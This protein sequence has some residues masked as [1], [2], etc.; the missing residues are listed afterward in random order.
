MKPEW[1][2]LNLIKK[3]LLFTIWDDPGIPFSQLY[4]DKHGIHDF[5]NQDVL[6]S[7]VEVE[8]TI[9]QHGF[10]MMFDCNLPAFVEN[11]GKLMPYFSDTMV[12]MKRLDN[13]QQCMETVLQK[14]VPGDFIETGVW[15]GG[16]CIL[17]RAV[18]AAYGYKDRTVYAADSFKGLPVPNTD[19]YPQDAGQFLHE[20]D[21]LAVKREYVEKRFKVF[22]LLDEQIKFLEG[23]FEDTLPTAPIERLSVLRLDGDMYGSTIV[24]L[25]NLYPKLSDGGFCIIDD[26]C[27]DSCSQAVD[28]YRALNGISS[29]L[30]SIDDYSVYWEK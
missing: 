16:C 15:R 20:I 5:L 2:Y 30:I 11:T 13:I 4:A 18:L 22:G 26:Y 19:L 21:M 1:L 28:Y 23:W 8:K 24:A 25:E 6:S 29:R 17:M 12:S 27:I 7:L 14:D 10:F 9:N 3:A